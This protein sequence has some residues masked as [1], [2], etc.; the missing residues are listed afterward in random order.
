MNNESY[1]P[2]YPNQCRCGYDWTDTTKN[3]YEFVVPLYKANDL[4]P[5]LIQYIENLIRKL[6]CPASITFVIDGEIDS[7]TKFLHESLKTVTFQWKTIT[8]SRNF[9]VGPALMAGFEHSTA[10]I[11]TAFGADL[12]EPSSIFEDFLKILSDP[13]KHI[14]LGVRKTRDDPFFMKKASEVYW[15]MF[16]SFIS[17]DLPKGG[18]DVCALSSEARKSLCAMDE[19]NTNI[20][21]QIDWLG[22]SRE[23]VFFD[24]Q[25]RI[26]GKSS[27]K[28]SKK[29]KL[30]FD[31]FYGFT[32]LP[33][34]FLLIVSTI[35]IVLQSI[36]GLVVLLSWVL[37]YVEVPGYASIVFLQIFSTNLILFVISLA[38]GYTIRTFEN[39]KL[40]PKYVIQSM[41]SSKE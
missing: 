23:F 26:K 38:S 2:D 32:D 15:R 21:A 30:F 3:H 33:I 28:L 12:Q 9:G 10:C 13:A 37:G 17:P 14:A 24:R 41:A 39:S 22:F 27:W 36:F 25:R 31:S 1:P 5:Q 19:K 16:T 8:L 29:M 35:G 20:T 40:R 18:F 34:Y 4:I 7:T 11:V 6:P